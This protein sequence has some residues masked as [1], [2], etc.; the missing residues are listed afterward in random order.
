MKHNTQVFTFTDKDGKEVV[1]T[2]KKFTFKLEDEFRAMV[3]S[4]VYD[5]YQDNK[6]LDMKIDLD[7]VS[8]HFNN[9]LDGD[10]S[11]IDWSAQEKSEIASVYFFFISFNERVWLNQQASFN[12]TIVSDII[13][14]RGLLSSIPANILEMLKKGTT[15]YS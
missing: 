10:T 14:E 5:G 3:G 12:E 9:L 4:E 7:K 13:S 11:N 8:G 2:S 1:L 15:K 6:Q